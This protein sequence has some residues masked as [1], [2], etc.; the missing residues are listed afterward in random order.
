MRIDNKD[1]NKQ[2]R[3]FTEWL[4]DGWHVYFTVMAVIGYF[5]YLITTTKV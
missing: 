4:F 2:Y 1:P 3:D 5:Y